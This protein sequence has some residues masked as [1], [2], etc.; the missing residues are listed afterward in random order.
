MNP[1][2]T[3]SSKKRKN[4]CRVANHRRRVG[5]QP[6][7]ERRSLIPV[8][9]NAFLEEILSYCSRRIAEVE[10]GAK[11]IVERHNADESK[12]DINDLGELS[13]ICAHPITFAES[14]EMINLASEIANS[15]L[16]RLLRSNG[17][18]G[19]KLDRTIKFLAQI[20]EL[21]DSFRNFRKT[22]R[23]SKSFSFVC[24]DPP[25]LV[26]LHRSEIDF[27]SVLRDLGVPI[28]QGSRDS[29]RRDYYD[30][31][32]RGLRAHAEIQLVLHAM[33]TGIGEFHPYIGCTLPSCFLC[34][35]F[36]G[37]LCQPEFRTRGTHGK[38]YPR[39]T[40]PKAPNISLGTISDIEHS[41]KT[42]YEH[43][44][45]ILEAP[46][47]GNHRLVSP[48]GGTSPIPQHE[49][50][51]PPA[52]MQHRSQAQPMAMTQ[53][54]ET[55]PLRKFRDASALADHCQAKNH[56]PVASSGSTTQNEPGA[57][58]TATTQHCETCPLRKFR[59]ASALADHCKAKNHRPVASSGSTTQNESGAPPTATTQHCETCPLRRFRSASALAQHCRAKNH[60]PV[61]STGS[62]APPRCGNCPLRRFDDAG[63]LVQ[64]CIALGHSPA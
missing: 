36:L 3:T 42:V 19:R 6:P 60:R 24:L 57:P 5:F 44:K 15:G 20:H 49:P 59:D 61:A 26:K 46:I 54:C 35:K 16:S 62:A 40:V 8:L 43:V 27:D 34:L 30:T 22:V 14:R 53:H 23:G 39:W 55:C 13:R 33:E 29:L 38:L 32:A 17:F 4:G 51:A 21:F 48:T 10:H 2:K 28:E 47:V 18:K 58:P 45:L 1:K 50:E 56:R 41:L 7:R 9:D 64:H 52:P 37:S 11:R 63:A 12:P 31:Q 25:P